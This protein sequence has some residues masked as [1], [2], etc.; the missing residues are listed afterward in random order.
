MR[1][2][3]AETN[4]KTDGAVI[5]FVGSFTNPNVDVFDCLRMMEVSL[6]SFN[7]GEDVIATSEEEIVN[8]GNETIS[9]VTVLR[10][11]LFMDSVIVADTGW[12]IKGTD[13]DTFPRATDP[14]LK[15]DLIA[16][17]S[18]KAEE[19]VF[20][21]KG[22]TEGVSGISVSNDIL[23]CTRIEENNLRGND[24]ET[25]VKIDG[26]VIIFVGSFTDSSVDVFNCVGMMEVSL[27][28]FN[29][30]EDTSDEDIVN[31]CNGTILLVTVPRP[32]LF[33]DSVIVAETGWFI[34]GTDK[35]MFP[36]VT[37]A[38]LVDDLVAFNSCEAEE[39]VFTTKEVTE[40]V[41]E[42]SVSNDILDCTRIEEN[43][44]R[45]NDAETNVKIDGAVIF[46]VGSFTNSSVDVFNCVR[47]MEVSL[48]SFSFGEDV[49]PTSEKDIVNPGNET[50]LLVPVPR[51]DLFMGSV[52][53]AETGWF[54]KGT[55]KDIFPRATD[56]A[57][58]DDLVAFNSCKAEETVFTIAGVSESSASNDDVNNV[59]DGSFCILK[60]KGEL[61]FPVLAIW[62]AELLLAG[63]EIKEPDRD[64]VCWTMGRKL[65]VPSIVSFTILEISNTTEDEFLEYCNDTVLLRPPIKSVAFLLSLFHGDI[66]TLITDLK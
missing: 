31:P 40:G 38:A 7:F 8:L 14:T 43:N 44:L 58:E 41:S 35:D 37:D 20:T 26:A 25:N 52:I 53:V 33:M 23:D 49:I 60:S 9:L 47:M 51:P 6:G 19:I 46:F 29:F 16:F 54:I 42:I 24:A 1:G 57:L 17:N 28:S 34:K 55:D 39:T 48:D 13:K 65:I 56:A 50:I 30:G 59:N 10:P 63:N 18:C 32:D 27:G 45:G 11:D 66:N 64:G 21:T 5:L 3:D 62:F 36:R 4:V 2:N 22:V 12:F 61:L 15:D